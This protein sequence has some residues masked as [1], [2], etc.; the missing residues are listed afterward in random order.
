MKLLT[1][2]IEKQLPP[3]KSTEKKKPEDIKIIVKFFN[4]AGKG[5]WYVTEGEKQENGDWLFFGFVDLFDKE[6]GYFTLNE[7]KS[8]KLPFGLKIER[9]MYFSNYT[10]KEVMEKC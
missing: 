3:I 4:P 8:V 7:L 6:L 10:L 2:E 5:S 9:D 1:K